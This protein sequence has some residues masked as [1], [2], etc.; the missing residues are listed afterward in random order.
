[1]IGIAPTG[2]GKTYAYGLPLLSQIDVVSDTGVQGIVLVPTRELALQAEKDLKRTKC[3]KV[4]IVAVY[5]G[6]DREAQL[7]ALSSEDSPLVVTGTPGRLGDLLKVLKGKMASLKWVVMDEADRMAT[8]VDMSKQVDDIMDVLGKDMNRRICLFSA[9]FPEA[10]SK[11]NDW[12]CEKHVVVKVNTITVGHQ[13]EVA[14]SK[15]DEAAESTAA[16]PD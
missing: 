16:L 1:M 14:A 12:I 9:T 5:G 6:V 15:D 8:Q 4:T 3:N 10:A 13:V 7:E 2:S 11:W